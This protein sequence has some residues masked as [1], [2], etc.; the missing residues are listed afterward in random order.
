[1][2]MHHIVIRGLSGFTIFFH[3]IS[4]KK[5][6]KMLLNMKCVLFSFA[7]LSETFGILRRSEGDLIKKY[8]LA[9]T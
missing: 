2:R 7:R 5:L 6:Q 3:I 4:Q 1:M 9:L 8:V